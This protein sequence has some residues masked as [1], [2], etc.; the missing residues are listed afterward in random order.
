VAAPVEQ[1]APAQVVPEAPEADRAPQW[2]PV[3]GALRDKVVVAAE[4]QEQ[5]AA[6]VL[7]VS[8]VAVVA[9]AS[10]VSEVAVVAV[11]SAVSE[12]AAVAVASAVLEVA[13]APAAAVV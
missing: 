12:V 5:G 8:E 6:V 9:V 3:C 10:A 13:A 1:V 4:P 11:A 2:I 7:E